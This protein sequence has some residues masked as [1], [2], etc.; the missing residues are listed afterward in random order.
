MKNHGVDARSGLG[1]QLVE[2]D[3]SGMTACSYSGARWFA[4]IARGRATRLIYRYLVPAALL[5]ACGA[6]SATEVVTYYYTDAQGTPLATA[7]AQGNIISTAEYR[8]YATQ[9][10]GQPADGPGYTGHVNDADAGLV[11]MQARYYDT[12]LGRFLSVDPATPS[13]GG[14]FKINRYDYANNNPSTNSDPDGR[15][16]NS[17]GRSTDPC[18]SAGNVCTMD[19]HNGYGGGVP[20]GGSN[21]DKTEATQIAVSKKSTAS[22]SSSGIATVGDLRIISGMPDDAVLYRAPDGELFSAP[23]LADFEQVEEAGATN[24]KLNV[25]GISRALGHYG[26]YDFQRIDAGVMGKSFIPEYTNASNFAVGVFMRGAGFTLNQTMGIASTFAN[27]K[28]SNAGS[29]LQRV[30]WINGWNA[31]N[32]GNLRP[33]Q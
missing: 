9:V 19:Y 3:S 12:E 27:L 8:P 1:G 4:S 29:P 17:D 14:T 20:S 26:T 18:D 30:W 6:S 13:A 5:F 28:S 2:K 21:G 22:T 31:A 7:D 33:L 32:T 23:A 10:L 25:L 15:N 24:G 16:T 11:Y